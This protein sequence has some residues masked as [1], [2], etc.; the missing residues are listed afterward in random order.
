MV[1][2]EVLKSGFLPDA[3]TSD[4]LW[5][6]DR[7]FGTCTSVRLRCLSTTPRLDLSMKSTKEHRN[8]ALS[9]LL[10]IVFQRIIVTW[11]HTPKKWQPIGLQAPMRMN[12]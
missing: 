3:V 10:L 4:G 7:L 11:T 8:K 1:V 5:H 9:P 2:S 6:S 12:R